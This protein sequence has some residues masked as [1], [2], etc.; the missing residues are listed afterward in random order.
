MEQMLGETRGFLWLILAHLAPTPGTEELSVTNTF[1]ERW[2]RVVIQNAENEGFSQQ[3]YG[4]NGP[5]KTKDSFN[6]SK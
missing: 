1:N 3:M 4:V 5:E 2:T 6:V